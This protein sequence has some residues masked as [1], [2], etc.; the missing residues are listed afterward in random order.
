[1]SVWVVCPSARKPEELAVW[2]AAWHM[3]GYKIA[4]WRDQNDSSGQFADITQWSAVSQPEPGY[5]GYAIAVNFLV[6]LLLG[7]DET[8]EWAVIAGDDIFPDPN[9]SAEE[10]AAECKKHF[11]DAAWPKHWHWDSKYKTPEEAIAAGAYAQEKPQALWSAANADLYSLYGVMQPTGDRFGE[12]RNAKDPAMR[13]AYI[14]RVCGSA[15]VGREFCARI[16]RGRGPLWPEYTHQFVDEELQN[17]AI[18]YGVLWQRR[19]LTHYHDHW[20]RPKPGETM[21]DMRNMPEFLKEANTQEH[22]IK[23]RNL[24]ET[25]RNAGFPG[26]EPL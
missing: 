5:P 14:D 11:L 9:K 1:M 22:W 8:F 23:Y 21:G 13:G 6:K 4:L 20:G 18:K 17:I 19:D 15:W 25:R 12:E 7:F 10:I 26:S 16:N 3:K 2:S 24:F